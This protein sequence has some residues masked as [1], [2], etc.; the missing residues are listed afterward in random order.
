MEDL[1][2]RD[3][4]ATEALLVYKVC[5]DQPDHQETRDLQVTTES[6]VSL[7]SRAQEAHLEMMEMLDSLAFRDF[8]VQEECKVKKASVVCWVKE[9]L[10]D[11]PDHL[12]KAWALTWLPCKLC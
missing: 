3:Q 9:D 2:Q 10:Q 5:P 6:M 4:R 12:E 11:L 8:L 7:E 1:D